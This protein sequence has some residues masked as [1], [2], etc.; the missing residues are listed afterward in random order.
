M[1]FTKYIKS[2]NIQNPFNSDNIKS[3][4]SGIRGHVQTTWTE[5]RVILT[6]PPPLVDKRSHF[7]DPPSKT[8][9]TFQ[10]PPL[11]SWKMIFPKNIWILQLFS[12]IQSQNW[13]CS[14]I[15]NYIKL[16]LSSYLQ[17]FSLHSTETESCHI[18]FLV[19]V[20]DLLS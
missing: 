12:F 1:L 11:R 2:F 10:E 4:L 6:P 18:K 17:S 16:R 20:R 8:M 14:F 3:I 13:D 15:Y 19:L 9:W 7:A 5:F